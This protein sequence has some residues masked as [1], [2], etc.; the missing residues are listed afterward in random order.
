MEAPPAGKHVLNF[1]FASYEPELADI[2]AQSASELVTSLR[3]S[4]SGF[5]R[6][7]SR[8]RG[9]TK[10]RS[11]GGA[12]KW[13]ARIGKVEGRSLFLGTFESEADAAKGALNGWHAA[14]ALRPTHRLF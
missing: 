11:D 8:F 5:A 13:E 6:G 4:S 1:P 7:A 3:R 2:R 12:D 10:H 14:D 9:V